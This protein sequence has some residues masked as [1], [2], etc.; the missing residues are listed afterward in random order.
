MS[1][2]ISGADTLVRAIHR[3]SVQVSR[4]PHIAT[5]EHEVAEIIAASVLRSR[6]GEPASVLHE[7]RLA[8][9]VLRRHRSGD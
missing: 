9:D 6:N 5:E 4:W 1:S 8:E 2:A 3:T 7:E